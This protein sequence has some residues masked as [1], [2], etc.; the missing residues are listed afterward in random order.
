LPRLQPRAL[1]VFQC[2][3]KVSGASR[4]ANNLPSTMSPSTSPT[5]CRTPRKR[6]SIQVEF[7]GPG[8][9]AYAAVNAG[10]ATFAYACV[11]AGTGRVDG[12]ENRVGSRRFGGLDRAQR[13]GCLGHV[14]GGVVQTLAYTLL[15]RLDPVVNRLR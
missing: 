9:A 2:S 15:H 11:N 5:L 4:L 7:A 1:S 8:V 6:F 13:I 10:C 12:L 14:L 3:T